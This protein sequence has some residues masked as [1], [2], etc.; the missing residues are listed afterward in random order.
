M[1][2][3][4]NRTEL[5]EFLNVGDDK[6]YLKQYTAGHWRIHNGK[7]MCDTETVDKR[8]AEAAIR[9]GVVKYHWKNIWGDKL[10]KLA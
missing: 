10:Y 9:D 2:R 8:V 3:I 1:H 7:L 4:T 5:V 6:Y